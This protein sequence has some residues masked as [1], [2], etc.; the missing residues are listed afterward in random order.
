MEGTLWKFNQERSRMLRSPLGKLAACAFEERLNDWD[1]I[2][3][4][5]NGLEITEDRLKVKE[6]WVREQ[7]G[8]SASSPTLQS[9]SSGAGDDVRG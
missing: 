1:V 7:S 2:C 6:N 8:P 3:D 4:L 5:P 9:P